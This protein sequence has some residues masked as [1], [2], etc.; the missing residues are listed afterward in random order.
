MLTADDKTS[1]RSL[2]EIKAFAESEPQAILVPSH[3]PGAWHELRYGAR[4]DRG[5]ASERAP[6]SDSLHT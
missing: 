5:G 3:D 1:R 4:P 2:R 6:A